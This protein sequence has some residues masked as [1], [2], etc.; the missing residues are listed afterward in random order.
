MEQRHPSVCFCWLS[1]TLAGCSCQSDSCDA[2]PVQIS[3]FLLRNIW[4]ESPPEV[5][6]PGREPMG[7]SE[8]CVG[9]SQLKICWIPSCSHGQHWPES[10]AAI[11]PNLPATTTMSGWA[12]EMSYRSGVLLIATRGLLFHGDIKSL[13]L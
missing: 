5:F 12:A 13:I 11:N 1:W 10:G 3:S 8:D 2:S 9:L 7:C 6:P 4:V